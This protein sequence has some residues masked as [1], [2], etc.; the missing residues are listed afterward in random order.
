M[1]HCAAAFSRSSTCVIGYLMKE[2]LWTYEESLKF[3]QSR[4]P[5][6]YTNPNY[7]FK[8]QLKDYE[9]ELNLNPENFGQN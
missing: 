2:N 3:V 7:G 1:I 8:Q 4:R 9:K 6:K 5:L